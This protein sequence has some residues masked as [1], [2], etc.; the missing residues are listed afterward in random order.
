MAL[1]DESLV[2]R[3]EVTAGFDWLL[4]DA[5]TTCAKTLAVLQAIRPY[6][7]QPVMRPCAVTLR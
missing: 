7:S 4:I 5:P 2:H 1:H 3:N 6:H